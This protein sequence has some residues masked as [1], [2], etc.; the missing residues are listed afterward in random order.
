MGLQI[1][2]E[3]RFL[4]ILTQ[5][6]DEMTS[7]LQGSYSG[8][9]F[10][11]IIFLNARIFSFLWTKNNLLPIEQLCLE[12]KTLEKIARGHDGISVNK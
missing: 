9:T 3:V 6:Y 8:L 7:L 1:P 2:M 5:I 12:K 4:P 11:T 10:T